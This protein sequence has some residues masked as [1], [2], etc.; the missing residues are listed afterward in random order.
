VVKGEDVGGE[1]NQRMLYTCMKIKQ[2]N[3]LKLF[4]EGSLGGEREDEF[5]QDALYACMENHNDTPLCN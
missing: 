3:L 5:N 2:L 4:S 1:H